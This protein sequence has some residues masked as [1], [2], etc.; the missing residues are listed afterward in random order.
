MVA[1]AKYQNIIFDCDSTLVTI[2]GLDCLAKKYHRE[3]EIAAI[4]S[5]GMSGNLPFSQ[6]IRR[7]LNILKLRQHDLEWLGDQYIHNL[8]TGAA[9]LVNSLKQMD[10]NIYLVTGG[11]RPAVDKLGQYL[12][13]SPK[14][15]WAS[16]LL[17]ER[18]YMCA[19]DQCVMTTDFGKETVVKQISKS[20]PTVVIG[21][22]MTDYNAGKHADMFIGFG[23][24]IK[25]EKVEALSPLY[26]Q[27]NNLLI[28]Q[29]YL[30]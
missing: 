2:E 11:P 15:I 13:I 5:L 12:D 20:G 17:E 8:T 24:V 4:T 3:E 29:Q 30:I 1:K 21:D 14:N 22:G 16:C 27:D 19:D 9:D 25:R 23:R 7:R 10:V 18:G 26:I 28:L 6:S